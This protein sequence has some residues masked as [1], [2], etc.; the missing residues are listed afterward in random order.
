MKNSDKK[1]VQSTSSGEQFGLG[2]QVFK[3]ESNKVSLEGRNDQRK[4]MKHI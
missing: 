2:I 1:N 4:A 3:I